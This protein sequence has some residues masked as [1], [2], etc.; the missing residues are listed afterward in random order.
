PER[1]LF[2]ASIVYTVLVALLLISRLPVYSGKTIRQRISTDWVI[3]LIFGLV[4]YVL[5][6]T[7]YPWQT[8]SVSVLAYLVFLP[9]SA[10]AYARRAKLEAARVEAPASET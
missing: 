9:L 4:F 3:P 5:L 7:T 2:Y 1:P 8:L 10:R 6:L